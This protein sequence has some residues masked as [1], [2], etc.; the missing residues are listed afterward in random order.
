[1]ALDN[2]EKIALGIG[3]IGVAIQLYSQHSNTLTY[4]KKRK[5]GAIGGITMYTGI[6]L[7]FYFAFKRA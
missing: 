7:F 4:D 3:A 5:Y 6:G 2:K 1:M